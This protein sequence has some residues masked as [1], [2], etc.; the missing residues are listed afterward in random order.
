MPGTSRSTSRSTS[1]GSRQRGSASHAREQIIN[2]LIDDHKQAK[3]AFRRF[4]K[5]DPVTQRNE[6]E[7]LVRRTCAALSIHATLEEELFYP[8]AREGLDDGA[9]IDEAEVEHLSARMLIERLQTMSADDEKFAA[10]FKVLG[11]YIKHH[12]KEEEGEIFPQLRLG[13][14]EWD[15]LCDEINARRAELQEQLDPAG[16]AA[17][18]EREQ[19]RIDAGAESAAR[20]TGYPRKI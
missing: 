10:T 13:R 16:D 14:V 20:D 8:A 12:V 2:I 17:A 11:E 18:A 15:G 3:T 19:R 4:D 7:A 6:C 9:L 1:G 5:L